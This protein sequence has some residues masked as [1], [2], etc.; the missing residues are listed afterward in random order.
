MGTAFCRLHLSISMLMAGS[1]RLQS[2]RT[3]RY[4]YNASYTDLLS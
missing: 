3:T 2:P 4:D 1:L